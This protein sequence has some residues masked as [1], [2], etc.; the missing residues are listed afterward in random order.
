[1]QLA[2]MSVVISGFL[3]W[4]ALAYA[5]HAS[6]LPSVATSPPNSARTDRIHAMLSLPPKAGQQ[7]ASTP[8]GPNPNGLKTGPVTPPGTTG[9]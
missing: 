3:L 4:S 6:S 2:R 1:M 8:S 5:Q 9:H 7:K